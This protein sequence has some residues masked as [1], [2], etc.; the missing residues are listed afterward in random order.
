[1]QKKPLI[2]FLLIFFIYLGYEIFY[3]VGSKELQRKY[4]ELQVLKPKNPFFEDSKTEDFN[5][6]G[7]YL[8]S[9]PIECEKYAEMPGFVEQKDKNLAFLGSVAIFQ[10]EEEYI[11]NDN[12]KFAQYKYVNKWVGF[13]DRSRGKCVA[14]N[15]NNENNPNYKKWPLPFKGGQFFGTDFYVKGKKLNQEEI[16]DQ[17]SSSRVR[18][19]YVRIDCIVPENIFN[20][21]ATKIDK[22][23]YFYG[24][25]FENPIIGDVLIEFKGLPTTQYGLNDSILEPQLYT[26]LGEYDGGEHFHPFYI[27]STGTKTYFLK[28]GGYIDEKK[29]K[30]I[31][32]GGSAFYIWV[33]RICIF[34]YLILFLYKQVFK[35]IKQKT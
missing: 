33:A 13:N 16:E 7:P 17:M 10:T 18:F 5:K 23:K 21:K 24:K 26:L 32:I 15:K 9:T 11:E 28:K 19:T 25:D 30:G 3:Q 31:I 27:N 6:K 22:G 4:T 14:W 1:M 8:I 29:V 34:V 20:K 2:Y 35:R 12:H